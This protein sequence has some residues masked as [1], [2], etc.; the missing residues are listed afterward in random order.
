[1]T[2]EE[3]A[4]EIIDRLKQEYPDVDA[5]AAADVG[6]IERIVRTWGLGRSRARD[7]SACMKIL[8]E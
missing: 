3:L 1:M 2:K 7:I 8:E 5:L 6:D 4:L